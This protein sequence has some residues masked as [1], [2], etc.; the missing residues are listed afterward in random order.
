M[1]FGFRV[2][3][4]GVKQDLGFCAYPNKPIAPKLKRPTT[5]IP[6]TKRMSQPTIPSY[7]LGKNLWF[8]IWGFG[9]KVWDLRFRIWGFG[10]K[11]WDLGFRIW[12]F[13]PKVWDL[14]FGI[15]GFG[16]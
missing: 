5:D 8:R 6:I 9:P 11:V 2:L 12:G 3:G 4:L 14:G 13:G 7:P 10:P 16:H 15:W 1:G